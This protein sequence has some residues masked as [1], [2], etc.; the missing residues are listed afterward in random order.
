MQQDVLSWRRWA[1]LLLVPALFISG[2]GSQEVRNESSSVDGE[3]SYFVSALHYQG[4]D[5]GHLG[6]GMAVAVASDSDSCI[7]LTNAH[8]VSGAIQVSVS[9]WSGTPTLYGSR[10]VEVVREEQ[11]IDAAILSY[12]V[13]GGCRIAKVHEQPLPLGSDIFTYG[14]PVKSHGVVTKGVVGGY[15]NV[16][17]KGVLMVSD[18]LTVQGNSG[19]G[20]FSGDNKLVGLVTGRT[21]EQ[22]GYAYIVPLCRFLPLLQV[23]RQT[24]GV[25]KT[26]V[27]ECFPR[28]SLRSTAGSKAKPAAEAP[29]AKPAAEAPK[30]KPAA[31]VSD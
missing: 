30:A 15:W 25:Q 17:D 7:L 23:Y 11:A 28:K 14:Q 29:K 19:G 18:M 26:G 8:I 10:K 31:G 12:P 16:E 5:K 2:C 6:L 22:R 13:K 4:R 20:V 24:E 21:V 3:T 1:A 9:R 27:K